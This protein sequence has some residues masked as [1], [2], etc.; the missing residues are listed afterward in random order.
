MIEKYK[1]CHGCYDNFPG[2]PLL[3]FDE[4]HLRGHL[5]KLKTERLYKDVGKWVFQN[6]V[7]DP[8]NSLPKETVLAPSIS[9]FKNS[10]D[11]IHQSRMYDF[12]N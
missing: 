7:V 3:V 11:K 4:N 8:W 12:S 5:L 9:C 10:F 1:L 2:E 6:R